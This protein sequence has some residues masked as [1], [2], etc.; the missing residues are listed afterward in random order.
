MPAQFVE[1]VPFRV[2]LALD[3]E[4]MFVEG[5]RALWLKAN[6]R[7]KALGNQRPGKPVHREAKVVKFSQ[8]DVGADR[9]RLEAGEKL[10]G[11]SL[12]NDAVAN[13]VQCR[14]LCGPAPAILG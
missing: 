4:L 9:S 5:D 1:V 14:L 2:L 8:V 6:F 7:P 3:D 12:D 10:L 11:L 13:Q